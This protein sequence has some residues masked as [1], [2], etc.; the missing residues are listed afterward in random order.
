M[1]YHLQDIA[2]EVEKET[3]VKTLCAYDGMEVEI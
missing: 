2:L 1:N 3:G